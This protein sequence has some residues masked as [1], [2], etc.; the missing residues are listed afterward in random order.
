MNVTV[1]PAQK[2]VKTTSGSA[3]LMLLMFG[4]M[5]LAPSDGNSTWTTS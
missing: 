5:S 1:S 4:V 3:A 2:L